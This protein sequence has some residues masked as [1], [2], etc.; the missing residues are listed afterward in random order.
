LEPVFLIRESG[1]YRFGHRIRRDP[2]GYGPVVEQVYVAPRPGQCYTVRHSTNTSAA[3]HYSCRA[4]LLTPRNQVFGTRYQL[5]GR[6]TPLQRP[7]PGQVSLP[8]GRLQSFQPGGEPPF[9]G[10]VPLY[11]C[12]LPI[13]QFPLFYFFLWIPKKGRAY[14]P[15]PSCEVVFSLISQ[16]GLNY[17]Y[18]RES[19]HKLGLRYDCLYQDQLRLR[20]SSLG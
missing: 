9:V 3:K 20:L 14:W 15:A 18:V 13:Y 2:N 6:A 4:W 8:A 10:L 17:G 11:N 12:L 16:S 1:C 7:Y 5:L 19:C